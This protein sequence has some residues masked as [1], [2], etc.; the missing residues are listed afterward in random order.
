MYI[1][2]PSVTCLTTAGEGIPRNFVFFKCVSDVIT[3]TL[4]KDHT[5]LTCGALVF[6]FLWPLCTYC[7]DH[8]KLLPT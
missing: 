7:A 5:N 3:S 8:G 2:P 1:L 4:P 6:L